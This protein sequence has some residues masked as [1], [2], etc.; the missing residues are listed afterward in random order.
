M[1]FDTPRDFIGGVYDALLYGDQ[2]LGWDII[3]RKETVRGATRE[4]FLDY[5][6]RWYKP[7][8]MVVGVGGQASTASCSPRVEELSADFAPGETGRRRRSSCRRRRPA[9]R[10]AH[11]AVRPG[12]PLP[13]RAQLPARAPG[14]LRAPAARHR[15]RR[16]H[17]VAPLHRGARAP[18]PRL[19]RLRR[20]TTATPT[21]ARS[22]RRPASTSTAST[23]R[24]R[25]S[26]ASCGGSPRSRCRPTSSRRRA[27]SRRA[28][29]CSSSRA[30]TGRSCSGCAAR[31]SRGRAP[32]RAEVL[33]GLDAVTAE[34]VQ[35]VAQDVIGRNAL[36]LALIGPFDDASASRSCSLSYLQLVEVR[37]DVLAVLRRP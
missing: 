6:G 15:A 34:D 4:T 16:R 9:R 18:R 20:P 25:R 24:S 13:R 17:V 37:A 11:E 28:A 2:P 33:A 1:Y 7:E 21:R 8:R 10:G 3:G 29:S 27:N 23:R 32:S 26:S 35:R 19:L 14:P 36:N 5:L 12:A 31:C 30:R 22:S